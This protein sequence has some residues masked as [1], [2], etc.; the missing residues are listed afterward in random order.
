LRLPRVRKS[1]LAYT[2]AGL[3]LLAAWGVRNRVA[4]MPVLKDGEPESSDDE[5]FVFFTVPGVT[6]DASTRRSAAAFASEGGFD[7]VDLWPSGLPV[8]EA[9]QIATTI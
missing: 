1:W 3:Q 4:R 2:A 9:S 6:L 7:V 5:D 8:A